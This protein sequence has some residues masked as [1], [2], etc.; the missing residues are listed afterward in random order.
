MQ[1]TCMATV[2]VP[3]EKRDGEPAWDAP[4]GRGDHASYCSSSSKCC[5]SDN[6][7]DTPLPITRADINNQYPHATEENRLRRQ[8]QP[9]T[10]GLAS[11]SIALPESQI[12]APGRP[13]HSAPRPPQPGGGG[14][15]PRTGPNRPKNGP[16]TRPG[17]LGPG[18][19]RFVADW[20]RR[21]RNTAPQ[22]PAAHPPP[23]V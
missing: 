18:P 14:Y 6:D 19:R 13:P 16:K 12:S 5:A 9:E 17:D 23:P 20:R 8:P 10:L 7:Y 1:R 22:H 4:P 11:P 2:P 21:A 3:R 15:P